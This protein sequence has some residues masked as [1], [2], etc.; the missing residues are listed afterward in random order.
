M[1]GQFIEDRIDLDDEGSSAILEDVATR[2]RGTM[3]E[4]AIIETL[5]D[6]DRR[7]S[8]MLPLG[9]SSG[10]YFQRVFPHPI[11][12]SS[13][14]ASR[15]PRCGTARAVRQS[16]G[17]TRGSR[18]ARQRQSRAHRHTRIPRE[19]AAGERLAEGTAEASSY[20]AEPLGNVNVSLH[21]HSLT[22]CLSSRAI[23]D[24]RPRP[25]RVGAQH[26]TPLTGSVTRACDRKLRYSDSAAYPQCW[27]PAST[28]VT[29]VR[30]VTSSLNRT[31]SGALARA[32]YVGRAEASDFLLDM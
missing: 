6:L 18:F 27:M 8:K 23:T 4:R 25:R 7:H 3:S 21:I 17:E 19:C 16:P 29:P 28:S 14:C 22:Q 5:S 24:L 11:G 20:A 2:F 31:G 1:L 13:G 10:E 15:I 12:R 30:V 9:P 26:S 32:C